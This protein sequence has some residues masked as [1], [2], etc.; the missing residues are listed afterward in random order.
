[1]EDTSSIVEEIKQNR[2]K[3]SARLVAEY[4][5]RL[6]SAALSL[7][8]DAAKSEDL[9]FATFE[10]VLDKIEMYSE[11]DAFYGWMY[12]IMLN[13]YRKSVR[14]SMVKNTVPIGGSDDLAAIGP[15]LD[16][17]T[18]IA[19]IDGDIVRAAVDHLP[20]KLRDMVVLHYFMDM[21]LWQIAK[22]LTIPIGTVQRRLYMARKLLAMRLGAKL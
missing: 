6:Y 11:R 9:V 12:T 1:M 8:G 10:S 15:Q 16:A 3:G 7:C 20:P 5:D 14:G 17:D 2:E 21:P 13:H 22:F 4:R 18:V 19:A